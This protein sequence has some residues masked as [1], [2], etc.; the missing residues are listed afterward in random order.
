MGIDLPTD[1]VRDH[2]RD[3]DETARM[4][5]E[6]R[7]AAAHIRASDGAYGQLVGKLIARSYLNPHGDE[8]IASY[9]K[10]VDGMNALADLLRVMADDFDH[11]DER[12]A[13]R[14]QGTR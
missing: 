5:D 2:A 11:S 14:L 3:V 12:A 13:A 9:G 10:A 8:A 1:E 7:S 6:A 4:L